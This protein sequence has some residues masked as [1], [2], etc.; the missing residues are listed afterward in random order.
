MYSNQNLLNLGQT[1]K[2]NRKD[3]GLLL[4]DIADKTRISRHI[5]QAI[6][7]GRTEDL[8]HPPYLRGFIL[9]YAK[10]LKMNAKELEKELK[11]LLPQGKSPEKAFATETLVEK[12][13]RL[14]PVILAVLILFV[15]GSILVFANIIRSY[16]KSPPKEGAGALEEKAPSLS[17]EEPKASSVDKTPLKEEEALKPS[18]ENPEGNNQGKGPHKETLELVV[19]ALG[20]LNLSYQLD[21]GPKKSLSLKKDQFEVL[22]GKESIFIKTSKSNMLYIFYNGKNQGLLGAGGEKEK[23]F[24]LKQ[25]QLEEQQ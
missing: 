6:E 25:N 17:P 4:K 12:D 5:L 21:K 1:L 16:N 23:T 3:Q 18:S 11:T 8:P 7:E 24:F 19:K 20:S 2:K 10:I 9:T 22:K 15:L 13:L 14:T